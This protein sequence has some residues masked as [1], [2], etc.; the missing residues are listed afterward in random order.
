LNE[1]KLTDLASLAIERSLVADEF[2]FWEGDNPD[3]F[4]IITEGGTKILNYFCLGEE[5][6]IAF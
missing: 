2:I 4:Y 6:V 3:W 1:D 5:L